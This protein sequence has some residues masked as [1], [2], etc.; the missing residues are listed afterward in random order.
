MCAA[1][2]LHV[3]LASYKIGFFLS[4]NISL[5]VC[6]R[7]HVA[8]DHGAFCVFRQHRPPMTKVHFYVVFMKG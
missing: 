2:E 1:R 3:V 6:Q 4:L 5:G 7:D 8:L